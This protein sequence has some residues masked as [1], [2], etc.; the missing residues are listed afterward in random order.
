MQQNK[1]PVHF[2]RMFGGRIVIKHGGVG[3]GFHN[4]TQKDYYDTDGTELYQIR[5]TMV[6]RE[7]LIRVVQ[8]S[9][10]SLQI[11]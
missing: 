7:N 8:V 5:N 2:V 1:E 6:G 3:S 4:T 11:A 10:L 9:L